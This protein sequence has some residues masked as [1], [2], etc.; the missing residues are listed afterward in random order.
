MIYGTVQGVMR[1]I[2]NA[3]WHV[4]SDGHVVFPVGYFSVVEVPTHAGERAEMRDAVF[5]DDET[6]AVAFDA[7]EA[8]WYFVTQHEDGNIY[9]TLCEGEDDANQRYANMETV[10]AQWATPD[11]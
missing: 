10:Y 3:G 11:E 6:E 9:V 2:V 4:K 8:G 1:S 7:V 5:S